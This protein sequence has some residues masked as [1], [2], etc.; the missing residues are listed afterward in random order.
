M[1]SIKGIL[2][3]VYR[4]GTTDCTNRGLSSN[5]DSLIMVDEDGK[6]F[7]CPHTTDGDYLVLVKDTCMG[8]ERLRAIPKSLLDSGKWTMFGGNFAHTSDSRF[9]SNSPIAIHDRVE[10]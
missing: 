10:N 5:N 4:S 8:R 7:G 1:K 3:C 9:P 6:G 2:I